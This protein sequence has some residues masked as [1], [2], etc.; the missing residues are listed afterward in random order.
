MFSLNDFYKIRYLL[1]IE[2]SL[3]LLLA[4]KDYIPFLIIVSLI[5]FVIVFYL[6]FKL[7]IIAIH[8]LFFSILAD[9]FV[10]FKNG[11]G[12]NFSI[13]DIS[14]V[15][16][17]AIG[18]IWFLLNLDKKIKIPLLVLLW[19]PFL[20]WS[21]PV[22]LAV[23]TEKLNILIFWKIYFAG[24]FALILNYFAINNKQQL[25]SVIFG[26]I[27]WGLILSLIEVNVLIE[28]GGVKSGLIG[29]FF[30]KNLLD[31]G[32]GRSNYL[33]SFFVLIIP[34][35]IGYLF[36]TKSIRLKLLL[37]ISLIILLSAL[38][39][40]LSRGAILS[41]FVALV[42]L[43]SRIL[44]ARTLAPFII[45]MLLVLVIVLLNPLT[46]VL[47]DRISAV[48]TSGSYFSRIN[49]YA[50]VW[51]TFISHPITGVGFGN[52]GEY[53]QFV[54]PANSS[55]SAHNIVLGMLGETGIIGALFFFLL[56]GTL[57]KKVY[58]E[59]KLESED[60]LKILRW[61]FFCA[62][63]GGLLHSMM[64]PTLEGIQY[65]IIFWSIAGV[66]FKLDLL[67]TLDG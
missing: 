19:I 60:S 2:I 50:I 24:F 40:T 7:P 66:Y 52:L 26:L 35:T 23:A 63:I 5:L 44:K 45:I 61:S 65:S 54:L 53:A 15:V 42:L 29:L 18:I 21:L 22:G 1:L 16:I 11:A 20:L 64:E 51:N 28:L 17:L 8:I 27:I 41:L 62:I 34:L 12:P 32:W 67:K 30:R 33:A 56:I 25:K 9:S 39:L 31:V 14:F 48:E 59:F 55:T 43:F 10:H 57:L 4:F 47:I 6:V 13:I 58:S 49:F 38:T 3:L 36:Y 37:T 46:F